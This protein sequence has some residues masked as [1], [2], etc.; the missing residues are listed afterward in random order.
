LPAQ[1][2]VK[3]LSAPGAKTAGRIDY[4]RGFADD[5]VNFNPGAQRFTGT[6]EEDL[7]LVQYHASDVSLGAGRSAK[8]WT[9][10]EQ[11][12]Q[13]STGE[14]LQHGL[15]LPPDWGARDAV[16]VARIPKGTQ[17]DFHQGTA[18]RQIGKNGIEYGGGGIQFRF[19]DFD[20]SW[21][22]QTKSLPK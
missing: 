20:P 2:G 1:P 9:T 7:I 14:A 13:F 3:L 12:N 11:A 10:T 4:S 15:A 18:R 21:I 22:I 19:S 17:V 5:L 6:L 8:W 16:S